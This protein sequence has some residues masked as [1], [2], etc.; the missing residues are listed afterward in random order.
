MIYLFMRFVFDI[1]KI[2]IIKLNL[3]DFKQIQKVCWLDGRID[4]FKDIE[5][6]IFKLKT[7]KSENSC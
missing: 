6:V 5:K 1:W 3:I 7:Y 2:L 4:F